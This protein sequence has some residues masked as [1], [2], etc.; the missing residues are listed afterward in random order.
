MVSLPQLPKGGD[1]AYFLGSGI[2]IRTT[3]RVE[4][5]LRHG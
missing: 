4:L 1:A 3:D 2:A 5:Y